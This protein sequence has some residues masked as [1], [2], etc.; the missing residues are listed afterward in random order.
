MFGFTPMIFSIVCWWLFRGVSHC[1]RLV[2]AEMIHCC[3][4][5]I[6]FRLQRY[7]NKI[8]SVSRTRNDYFVKCNIFAIFSK[9]EKYDSFRKESCKNIKNRHKFTDQQVFFSIY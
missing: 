7:Y 4:Q 5:M 8:I 9:I 1:F 3:G 2:G 6:H